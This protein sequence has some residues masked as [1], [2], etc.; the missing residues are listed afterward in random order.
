MASGFLLGPGG[1]SVSRTDKVPVQG[2]QKGKDRVGSERRVRE[3]MPWEGQDEV[4]C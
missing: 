2:R 3:S 4:P 1:T